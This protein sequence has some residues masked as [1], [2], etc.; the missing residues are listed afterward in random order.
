M[1]A[2]PIASAPAIRKGSVSEPLNCKAPSAAATSADKI[3]V[4]RSVHMLPNRLA[5]TPAHG[6]ST[7][8]LENWAQATNPTAKTECV[9]L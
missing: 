4:H 8:G 9:S 7:S 2:S 1:K 3:C 6:P 5:M